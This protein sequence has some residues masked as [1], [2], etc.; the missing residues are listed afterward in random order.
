MRI[1]EFHCVHLEN[2]RHEPDD[3]FQRSMLFKLYMRKT[4]VIFQNSWFIFITLSFFVT[5]QY[6]CWSVPLS[7]QSS[8]E[9][10]I[11]TS[12]FFFER[13]T[14]SYFIQ[15]NLLSLSSQ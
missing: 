13:I 15:A 7:S 5:L 1:T 10:A 11:E 4:E 9:K 12:Q 14:M 6:Q 2:S 3:R 8:K